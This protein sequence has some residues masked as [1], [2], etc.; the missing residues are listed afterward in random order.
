MSHVS[1]NCKFYP[2][3]QANDWPH[4]QA[5]RTTTANA[6]K[7]QPVKSADKI[8]CN[9]RNMLTMIDFITI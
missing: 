2:F 7:A 9:A 6:S 8:N 4:A 3:A 1:L 5:Q